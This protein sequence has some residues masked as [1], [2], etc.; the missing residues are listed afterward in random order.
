MQL[1][2]NINIVIDVFLLGVII[3]LVVIIYSISKKKSDEIGSGGEHLPSSHVPEQK[4]RDLFENAND[5]IFI[6]DSEL[7]FKDVNKKAVE[8]FGYSREEY[9]KLNVK[10]LIPQE[11][12]PISDQEFEK[13]RHDG[14][15][16]KFVGKTRTKDGRWLDIEVNSSAIYENGKI[17]GSRDIVRNITERKKAEQEKET[18]ISELRKA[19]DEI[20]NLKGILPL[21]GWYCSFISTSPP[22]CMIHSSRLPRSYCM[23]M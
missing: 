3:I 18:L 4:Y 11:Q 13:L 22:G 19:L 16:E 10:D 6:L 15:Y 9:L 14:A 2:E 23:T 12:Y 8:L 21:S 7:N 1:L 20:N 17:I 5:A